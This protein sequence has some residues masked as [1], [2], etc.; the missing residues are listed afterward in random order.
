MK[1]KSAKQSRL[2]QYHD[3]LLAYSP[4]IGYLQ[5]NPVNFSKYLYAV[6]IFPG[7]NLKSYSAIVVS[8]F[9]K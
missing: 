2:G 4:A 7:G 8:K 9:L 6:K 1:S 5:V 3:Q